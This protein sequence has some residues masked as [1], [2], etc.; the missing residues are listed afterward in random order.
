MNREI[1]SYD[2]AHRYLGGRRKRRTRHRETYLVRV[3]PTE[4]A[5]RYYQ[6]DVVTYFHPCTGKE[7]VVKDGGWEFKSTHRRIAQYRPLQRRP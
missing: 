7:P 6:T 1:R 5:V 4:I 2:E 3:S